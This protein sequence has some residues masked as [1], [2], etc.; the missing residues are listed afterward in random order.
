MRTRITTALTL[1][2]L[3]TLTAC[4]NDAEDPNT[5]DQTTST[6][7]LTKTT[8]SPTEEPTS[9]EPTTE[10]P[11]EGDVPPMDYDTAP[12]PDGTF[13]P[14]QIPLGEP[15]YR[16]TQFVD[17]PAPLEWEETLTDF[18]CDVDI[19]RVNDEFAEELSIAEPYVPRPGHVLCA[20]TISYEN[21]GTV[22][23]SFPDDPDGVISNGSIYQQTPD[24][25]LY[26]VNE[27]L[28]SVPLGGPFNPGISFEAQTLLEV[29]EG[30]DVDAVYLAPDDTEVPTHL[31]TK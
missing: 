30:L 27:I 4:G 12:L 14:N 3:L 5:N 10:E 16:V 2:A 13:P 6:S 1:T 20:A 22:P 11:E 28:M 26:I 18:H 17:Q 21:I 9:E 8:T 23:G 7:E 15:A 24:Y 19:D 25:S 31:L 29:P